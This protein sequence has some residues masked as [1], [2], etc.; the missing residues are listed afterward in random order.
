[1]VVMYFMSG[2]VV[3]RGRLG[4]TLCITYQWYE[5]HA[6]RQIVQDNLSAPSIGG[7]A[8]KRAWLSMLWSHDVVV[9]ELCSKHVYHS[10]I[11]T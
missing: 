1:M 10:Y 6:P 2:D 4:I 5:Y 8:H 3:V 11:T 9:M 7:I